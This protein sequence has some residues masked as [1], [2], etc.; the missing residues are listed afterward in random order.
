MNKL[1]E[2]QPVKCSKIQDEAAGI[3][4]SDNSLNIQCMQSGS[5]VLMPK[6]YQDCI[7]YLTEVKAN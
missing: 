4:D 3:T 2:P 5:H 7:F 1:L 6:R